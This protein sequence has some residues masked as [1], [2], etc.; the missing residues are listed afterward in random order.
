MPLVDN[1]NG[2][3]KR[4]VRSNVFGTVIKALGQHE[5]KV[6]FDFNSQT[7]TVKSKSL[8]AVQPESGIPLNE[9]NES[10]EVSVL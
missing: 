7:K 10:P 9:Q 4:R 5:W 2:L 8:K 3:G 1:P 6:W